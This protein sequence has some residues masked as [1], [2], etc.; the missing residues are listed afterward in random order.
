[1]CVLVI[2]VFCTAHNR[3]ININNNNNNNNGDG[4]HQSNVTNMI[5]CD[6]AAR[7]II[8]FWLDK[9]LSRKSSLI[10]Y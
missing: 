2:I 8:L 6:A 4:D 9:L 3:D 7:V 5:C 1:M 10:Y